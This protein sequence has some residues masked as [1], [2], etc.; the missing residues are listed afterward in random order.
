MRTAATFGMALCFACLLPVC[1]QPVGNGRM[2]DTIIGGINVSSCNEFA[3]RI[4]EARSKKGSS[5]GGMR[6]RMMAKNPEVCR[7]LINKLAGSTAYKL[8]DCNLIPNL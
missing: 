6:D 3:E 7:Q 8:F 4:Q 1:A 2:F 5:G